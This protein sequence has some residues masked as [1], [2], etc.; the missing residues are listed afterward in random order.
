MTVAVSDSDWL[1]RVGRALHY[2]RGL[3]R[4]GE[5]FEAAGVAPVVVKGQAI[6]DATGL[7][8]GDRLSCD[9]DL[10]VGPDNER[11]VAEVLGQ[12]AY[13]EEVH[14][15][16][17]L[18]SRLLGER[19]F[20][21]PR[22]YASVEVHRV[23]DKLILRPIDYAGILERAQACQYPGLRYPSIED[24]FLLVVLH[25]ASDYQIDEARVL[26]DL[27]GLMAVDGLDMDVVHDRARRW[28]LRVALETWLERLAQVRD[29]GPGGDGR[30]VRWDLC[31]WARRVSEPLPT[32]PRY[33][34][35]LAPWF[36]SPLTP[37]A[38][39]IHYAVLRTAEKVGASLRHS[40]TD[41]TLGRP[42]T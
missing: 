13:R 30:F 33:F 18:T 16:R 20:L 6:V 15:D 2:E 4:L 39:L 8:P 24:L 3:A 34:T 28:K 7:Q 11:R 26:N 17:R 41:A 42:L 29:V 38:G 40:A 23:F 22:G 35:I 14:T 5:G 19:V 21:P 9:V 37:A 10:L 25:A 12:L 27:E 36:D 1:S 31:Q 32:G